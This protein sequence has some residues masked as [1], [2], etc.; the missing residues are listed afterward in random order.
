MTSRHTKKY[1]KQLEVMFKANRE[2]KVRYVGDAT[3]MLFKN[4]HFDEC[5]LIENRWQVNRFEEVT[6]LCLSDRR[7]MST[8][9]FDKQ[10]KVI[11]TQDVTLNMH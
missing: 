8:I 4:K 7:I 11:G 6:T 9:P 1:K 5:I 2:M 10:T 3:G